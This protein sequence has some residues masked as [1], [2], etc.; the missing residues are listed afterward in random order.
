MSTLSFLSRSC[1]LF[2]LAL[3]SVS[4]G[5]AYELTGS[6]WSSSTVLMQLQLGTPSSPL[7]D[8]STRWDDV[9]S[10]ALERWNA[11]LGRTRFSAVKGS[12]APQGSLNGYNNVFFSPTVYGEPFGG[13]VLGITLTRTRGSGGTIETDVIVNS[14]EAWNSYRGN[15]RYNAHDLERVLLHEFGHVLGL[16]HPDQASPA[17]SVA[18]VMNSRI[19]NSYTPQP[20]DIAG[21]AAL[22]GSTSTAPISAAPLSDQSLAAGAPLTL[23]Y[24][25]SGAN[26]AYSW[27][28]KPSA[29]TERELLNG[30]GEPWAQPTFSLFSAQPSDSGT[31]TVTARNPVGTATTSAS[32][33]TVAPV[34]TANALLANL[35]SRGRAG[36]G[37]DTFIVGFVVT[38]TTPKQVLVR[39]VGPTLASQ[40]VARPLADPRLTLYKFA[41]N[42]STR[43]GENDD[44][45]AN[46]SAAQTLRTAAQRLGAFALPDGSKDAALLVTLAPGIYMAHA[47]SKGA[48]AGIAL[49]EAY[50]A[51][52]SLAQSLPR[53]MLNLSTRSFTGSGEELLI[54]GF[55]VSGTTPKQ[56]LLR[57][58]GPGL[59]ARGVANV[60]PDP[61]LNVYRGS[62]RIADND[63]WYYS[64]QRDILPAIFQKVGTS[65]LEAESY[66]S[67]LLITL[68]PGVY[69][70]TVAGRSGE[71][72]AVLLEVFEVVN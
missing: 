59:T 4:T 66:D 47:D 55:V 11:H 9:A 6:S 16:G 27:T 64:N 38:G 40:S 2:A 15:L 58:I 43:V 14:A 57:A 19:G 41:D 18:A 17:Q 34:S 67:A 61:Y 35:S 12:S 51:D 30:D 45:S 69:S 23:A 26:L 1:A 72:G 7:L 20:D 33:V 8:G 37:A 53:R 63:D 49:V 28:F 39:A 25:A 70:A 62:T 42:V 13:R 36:S 60:N 31:Y 68:P 24:S 5:G 3:A 52:G 65:P 10:A 22:Y 44:W 32:R 54:A 48:P 50:D 21:A 46:S 56:I 29:G 71:T